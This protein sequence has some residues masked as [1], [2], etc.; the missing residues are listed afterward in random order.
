MFGAGVGFAGGL[1][2]DY[3]IHD[4]FEGDE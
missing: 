2:A 3:L 1:T 4:G